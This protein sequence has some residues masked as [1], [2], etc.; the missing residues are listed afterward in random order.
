MPS[1]TSP[2]L[3]RLSVFQPPVDRLRLSV[4]NPHFNLASSVAGP[5]ARPQGL[6]SAACFGGEWESEVLV[7]AGNSLLLPFPQTCIRAPAPG[8]CDFPSFR[9]LDTLR[10]GD[11]TS[12]L[13]FRQE[14]R[15]RRKTLKTLWE[16]WRV[17]PRNNLHQNIAMA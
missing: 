4:D 13:C 10:K 16:G 8:V 2:S 3:P 7:L 11:W 14:E 15:E 5:E 1:H 17:D 6:R 12:C 9:G